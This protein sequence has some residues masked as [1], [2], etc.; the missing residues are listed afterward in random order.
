MKPN[1]EAR[2]YQNGDEDQ[3]INILKSSFPEWAIRKNPIAYWKWKYLETPLSSGI[4]VGIIDGKMVCV[5]HTI[6]LKIKVGGEILLSQYGDDAATDPAFRGK[7][8]FRAL[9][10]LDKVYK[11]NQGIKFD[12]SVPIHPAM[13]SINTRKGMAVSPFK[14]RHLI[15]VKNV[16]I[17]IKRSNIKN[18]KV[19]SIGLS[20]YKIF[21]HL[22]TFVRKTPKKEGEFRIDEITNFD[23]KFDVFWDAIKSQ[24][25]FILEKS[26]SYLN[27]RYANPVSGEY[28]KLTA[29]EGSTVLGYIIFEVK[30]NGSFQEGFILDL[31]FQKGREDVGDGLIKGTLRYLDEL[32]VNATNYRTVKGSVDYP[33]ALLNGFVDPFTAHD[34]VITAGYLNNLNQTMELRDV[35]PLRVHFMFG[36]YF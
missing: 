13:L 15:R 30:R 6:N 21:N 20:F 18:S 14:I 16:N 7:G 33:L 3:I 29:L 23:T 28:K 2:Y 31:L 4:E 9:V 32:G 27:W 36:D 34:L 11:A 12:Y 22:T 8:Y 24:Y 1:I 25:D 35:D 17:Y 19:M 26:S 5:N 10:E